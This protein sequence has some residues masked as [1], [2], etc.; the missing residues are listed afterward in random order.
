M[1]PL[2][3]QTPDEVALS[4]L[5]ER[6]HVWDSNPQAAA[7]HRVHAI[8]DVRQRIT[9]RASLPSAARWACLARHVDPR[10]RRSRPGAT[11]RTW[12]GRSCMEQEYPRLC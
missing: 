3:F 8:N 12:S 6:A 4:M 11:A 9:V 2:V 5:L 1:S 10:C 7:T